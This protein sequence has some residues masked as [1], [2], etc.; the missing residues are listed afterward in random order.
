MI[1]YPNKLDKIFDKLDLFN[2]KPVIVGGYI[3]DSLMKIYSNQEKEPRNFTLS[4]DID[5][6]AYGVSS[7]KL[8]EELLQ[9]FGSVNSVGKSFGV[10]K[11]TFSDLDL[12]FSLPRLDS[13]ISSGHK[14]FA[15]KTPPNIDFK[16]AAFRRDFTINSIGY[17]IR[18]KKLLDP[19]GGVKDLKNGTL[20]AVNNNSFVEDP[21]RVLRAVQFAA[22][23]DFKLS[24]STFVLCRDMLKKRYVTRALQR[25]GF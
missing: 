25:E 10:C 21:L 23:F 14:G 13:K 9:E 7:L 5:I 17:D 24:E 18:D 19:Y 8:L 11:L 22:R 4:K 2:I 1:D 12:D 6:E 20:N 3:R 15:V 16:K